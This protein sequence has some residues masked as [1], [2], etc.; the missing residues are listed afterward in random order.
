LSVPILFIITQFHAHYLKKPHL[1]AQ[2]PRAA[3][4]PKQTSSQVFWNIDLA[5]IPPY[6]LEK[7]GNTQKSFSLIEK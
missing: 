4:S 6:Q 5:E 3:K 7:F 1:Q 2:S